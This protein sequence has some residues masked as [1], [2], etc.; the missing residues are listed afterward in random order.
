MIYLLFSR[1]RRRRRDF[2]VLFISI[3]NQTKCY[4]KL[5]IY[6]VFLS[7]SSSISH[8]PMISAGMM[9]HTYNWTKIR[10]FI[11]HSNDM[12]LLLFLAL[13][14][15][16]YCFLIASNLFTNIFF[17]LFS[18]FYLWMDIVDGCVFC[19]LCVLWMDGQAIIWIYCQKTTQWWIW[20]TA[21]RVLTL[22]LCTN[23]SKQLKMI[24][25]IHTVKH[26][27]RW[28]RWPCV[29]ITV[30][31]CIRHFFLSFGDNRK[32][33]ILYHIRN[34][35]FN[36]IIL[37]NGGSRRIECENDTIYIVLSKAKQST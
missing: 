35:H 23:I 14:I 18:L 25:S 34:I 1:R 6:L 20:S 5:S 8:R 36:Q 9:R 2:C 22:Y 37:P 16:L 32:M 13:F 17:L 4:I 30:Q 21:P 15:G 28:H 11:E 24:R 19:V 33:N 27:I 3:R 29:R 26:C 12:V 10:C 7:S 31:S